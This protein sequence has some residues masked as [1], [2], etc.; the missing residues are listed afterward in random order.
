EGVRAKRVPVD[1]ASHSA[2][3][4]EL[5]DELSEVLA[6][7]QSRA[8]TV[9]VYSTLTGRVEDGSGMDA[10]YWFDNLRS[11]VR[12]SD[13]VTALAAEGFGTFVECSPH[14]VLTMS[15]PDDV[16]AVG[17]LKRDEGGLER[18]LLSLGEAVVHGVTPDWAA[19]IPDG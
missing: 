16:V 5:R 7:I 8:G 13:A 18:M 2:H 12:F 1:Y 11:T 4:D 10:G 9:P 15:L 14:P 6:P 3:V 17:S 19:V